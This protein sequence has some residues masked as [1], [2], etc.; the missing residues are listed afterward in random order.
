MK[1]TVKR[2]AAAE[3][4]PKRFVYE[5]PEGSSVRNLIDLLS[6]DYGSEIRDE[7][8]EN[9]EIADGMLIMLNGLS[10]FQPDVSLDTELKD[11]DAVLLATM[12]Y[13]G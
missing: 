6:A 7:L 5:V 8:L 11:G 13:G 2:I 12:V 1:I 4:L 10:L 9:G 3:C